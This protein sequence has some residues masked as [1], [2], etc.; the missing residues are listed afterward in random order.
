MSNLSMLVPAQVLES[1]LPTPLVVADAVPVPVD[2]TVAADLN[3]F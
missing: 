3:L 1:H 2:Q